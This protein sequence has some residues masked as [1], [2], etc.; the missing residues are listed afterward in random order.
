[1]HSMYILQ[2]HKRAHTDHYLQSPLFDQQQVHSGIRNDNESSRENSEA[3]HIRPQS[4]V[5]E[6]ERAEDRGAG[7]FDIQTIFVIDEGKVFDLVDN[8][9]FES[10]VEYRQLI[11]II[12]KHNQKWG[13]LNRSRLT[14][15]N[16]KA[17]SGIAS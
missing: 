3:D 4:T 13:N 15:C 9:S 5:I 11:E 2:L 6:A 1:M 17:A 8:Q 7:Y 14:V 10:V 12:S 16:H